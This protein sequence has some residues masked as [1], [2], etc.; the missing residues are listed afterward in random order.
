MTGT[1]KKGANF[2]GKWYSPPLKD[3]TQLENVQR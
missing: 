2:G 3:I 1:K